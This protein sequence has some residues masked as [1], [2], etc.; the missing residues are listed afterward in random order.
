M[1]KGIAIVLALVMALGLVG[2]A[3]AEED[4]TVVRI[5]S[6]KG[7]TTMGLV[8]LMQDDKNGESLNDYEFTMAGAADEISGKLAT[9]DLDMA[10]IPA[11]LAA[12]LYNNTQGKIQM[13]AINTLGVLYVVEAG[14]SIQSIEDLKGKTVLSTG[15][16]TTPEYGLNFVLSKNGIDPAKDLTIE[17]KSE[18][19]EAAAAL[20]DGSATI[21]VLPQPFVTTAMMNN[22]KLRLALSL[23]DEWAKVEPESA[24]ITGVAVV[25]AEFAQQNPEAVQNFLSEYQASTEY[26]NANPQE[27]SVW[28]EEADIAPAA[29]AEK[30]I[31]QCN[32][33]CITGTEMK[34][35][36]E[37]YLNALYE[38]NPKAVGGQLPDEAF[39]FVEE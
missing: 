8:K 15:K 23:T 6:L 4:K 31:P 27:A 10:L 16:G 5:G 34:E 9:G 37:G 30:A 28:I 17:F 35:K 12:V 22:D 19:T 32:I 20:A 33:V 25:N 24:M 7:P 11:N 14:D 13:T 29:V 39:Y 21:A 26:V 2:L 36:A 38:Q 18:A 3:S 1:K